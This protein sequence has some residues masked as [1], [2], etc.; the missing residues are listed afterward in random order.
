MFRECTH[1]NT[2]L[3]CAR[4]QPSNQGDIDSCVTTRLAT[5]LNTARAWFHV[6]TTL[7]DCCLDCVLNGT[8]HSQRGA[9]FSIIQVL[10]EDQPRENGGGIRCF[11]VCLCLN[12]QGFVAMS[13]VAAICIYTHRA[14]CRLFIRGDFT[15]NNR[16]AISQGLLHCR[17]KQSDCDYS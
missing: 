16:P 17:K 2:L 8:P 11:G 9:E 7:H 15:A 4:Q 14:R 5:P 1:V 3:A 12:H 10:S 6:C 13:V